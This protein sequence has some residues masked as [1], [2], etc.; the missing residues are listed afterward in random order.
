MWIYLLKM[1]VGRNGNIKK[2]QI[3]F[4]KLNQIINLLHACI[5]MDQM[6]IKL[7]N[8]LMMDVILQ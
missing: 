8:C 1:E 7:F 5:R 6:H 4:S 2:L 3:M